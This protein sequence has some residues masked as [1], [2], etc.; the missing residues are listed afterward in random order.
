MSEQNLTESSVSAPGFYGKLPVL[1][2]F[3]SR[4]IGHD[5]IAGWD[6]W[7]QSALACSKEALGEQWLECYLTSPI[8]RFLLSPGICG[9][10]AWA[11]VVMP[12]VDRV[13]RYFPLTI[14][15]AVEDI[16]DLML[17]T[18]A[19]EAWYVEIEN[20]ALSA[21]EQD[22][23]AD[24]IDR[25]L[26]RV[27]SRCWRDK[28]V[29]SLE[30]DNHAGQATGKMACFIQSQSA[31]PSLNDN[32]A[33]LNNCLINHCLLGYSLWH[34]RGSETI[35]AGMLMCEGL[36]PVHAYAGLLSGHMSNRGWNLQ[37]N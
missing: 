25:R 30:D 12:S 15:V 32:L 2:D 29:I 9:N 6:H 16:A 18:P 17:F 37:K 11:G 26:I 35:K 28:S 8:W 3:V 19:A 4:R 36:P 23:T 1:G 31:E 14:A 7:M 10:Q 13:G 21:L 5:F 27:D 22:L 24:E 34:T 33:G 20:I